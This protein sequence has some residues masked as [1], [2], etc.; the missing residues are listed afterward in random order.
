IPKFV[1]RCG[2][3]RSSGAISAIIT[4]LSEGDEV[5]DPI[6]ELMKS[7]LDGHIV[8]SRS[9]AERALFPAID[10]GRSVSRQADKLVDTEHR[11]K[12]L[13]VL[14]WIGVYE[15]S[16]T[17]VNTGLYN[18]GANASIDAAIEK[19]PEILRF[20]KQGQGQSTSLAETWSALE[21]VVDKG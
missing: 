4:V 18:K 20:L 2:A 10:V 13:K 7:L 19:H 16:R 17:L 3:L 12:A 11:R 8:L 5:D 6:C 14:E 9:L 15:S 1:E 21:Q